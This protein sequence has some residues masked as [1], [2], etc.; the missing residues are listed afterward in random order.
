[1]KNNI[2]ISISIIGLLF[3]TGCANSQTVVVR[4]PYK[5]VVVTHPRRVAVVPPVRKPVVV[6]PAKTVVYRAP[7]V[8]RTIPPNWVTV[9]YN[10][11]PYYY[12]DGIYYIPTET[13]DEFIP[14][15]PKV[16]TVVPSLP[17]GAVKKIIDTN[18]YY[19]HNDI[20]YKKIIVDETTKYEVVSTT[21]YQK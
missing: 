3:Y 4:K 6:A 7:V 10:D 21:E 16:G 14:V 19:E 18:T 1:M 20:L 11:I 2:L 15:P 8:V 13:K 17:E 5:T 12:V 9:Y